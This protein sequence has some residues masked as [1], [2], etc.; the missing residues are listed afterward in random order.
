MFFSLLGD[1]LEPQG[2]EFGEFL[3]VVSGFAP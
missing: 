2:R 1:V 3:R